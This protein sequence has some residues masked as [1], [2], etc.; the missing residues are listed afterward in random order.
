M[1]TFSPPVDQIVPSIYID[2][3]DPTYPSDPL[4]Q[5]L[6]QHYKQQERGRNVFSMSDGTFTEDQPPNWD[7]EP[8]NDPYATVFDAT[9]G[10]LVVTTFTQEPH[11]VRCYF[12][13][14]ANKITAAEA[15]ALQAAGYATT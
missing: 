9:S 1:P 3:P 15:T 10:A 7:A 13:G 11:I 5:R 6:M 8:P 2:P 4:M 14:V 12:G